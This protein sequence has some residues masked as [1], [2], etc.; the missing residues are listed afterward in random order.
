MLRGWRMIALSPPNLTLISI[1]L[2][3][4][5]GALGAWTVWGIKVYD[6]VDAFIAALQKQSRF[7]G[8][9]G[10]CAAISSL[11]LAIQYFAASST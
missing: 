4:A 2:G 1:A 8:A 5:G 11:L 10:F 9:A 7:A 3:F 6:N